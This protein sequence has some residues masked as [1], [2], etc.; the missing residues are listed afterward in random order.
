MFPSFYVSTVFFPPFPFFNFS[1]IYRKIKSLRFP[2]I[3][4][5][6]FSSI[7]L[8]LRCCKTRLI[9]E[10][11]YRDVSSRKSINIAPKMLPPHSPSL[12]HYRLYPRN[13]FF[14]N[15]LHGSSAAEEPRSLPLVIGPGGRGANY[16]CS[17]CC[18][19]MDDD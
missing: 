5:D 4:H 17:C 18:S 1:Q 2:F 8:F 6:C 9:L 14:D 11:S 13:N 10:F 12:S 16:S 3:F 7:L 19:P 15:L